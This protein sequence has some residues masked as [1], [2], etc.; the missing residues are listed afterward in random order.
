MLKIKKKS[1]NFNFVE[2][3]IRKMTFGVLTTAD[4]NGIPHSAGILYGV[5]PPKSKFSL[6]CLTGT[7]YKKVRNIK[8]NPNIAFV[9][10]YPHHLLRFVPAS[11]VQFQGK[12]EIL[13]FDNT[14]AQEAFINKNILKMNLK[15]AESMDGD[16]SD[17]VFI[18]IK[19]NQKIF[20]YGLG[21]SLRELSKNV[22]IGGYTVLIPA[23][24]Y[25]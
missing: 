19:P 11:C 3:N 22:E 8:E 23:E 25:Q 1:K 24:R 2:K 4:K 14:E 15:Q 20:C 9:I 7:N 13:P 10:P 6:F 16:K 12:A 18:K 21:I 5:S 17:L